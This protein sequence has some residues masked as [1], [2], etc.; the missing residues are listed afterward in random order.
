MD[1]MQ[2]RLILFLTDNENASSLLADAMIQEEFTVSLHP[3]NGHYL[4]S[5]LTDKTDM[6]IIESSRFSLEELSEYGRLRSTYLGLLVVLINDIDE[7]LQVMLYEQGIDELLV[8]PVSP[9]LALARIRALF[10]RN[11]KRRH[12]SSLNFKGLEINGGERRLTYRG[13]EISLS[14]REFDLLWYLAQNAYSTL[15]REQLYQN[16][17]GVEYNGYDRAIDM[18]ISRLRTKLIQGTDLPSMIRTVRGK[19]YL[20]AIG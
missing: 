4:D 6:L 1:T 20:F 10:R 5:C 12:P 14:S 16:I 17:F 11:E 7:M 3:K 15:N 9:L 13:K 19:G 8:K 2:N 18:Y